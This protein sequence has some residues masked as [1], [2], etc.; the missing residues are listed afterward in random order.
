MK[1]ALEEAQR[2]GGCRGGGAGGTE[3][4]EGGGRTGSLAQKESRRCFS[5]RA[6]CRGRWHAVAEKA[7]RVV[8]DRMS[9]VVTC[10]AGC[11]G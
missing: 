4:E 5:T 1:R 11:L 10:A 8:A 6:R 9:R 3:A 2:S 7:L